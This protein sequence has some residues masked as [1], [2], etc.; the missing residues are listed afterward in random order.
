MARVPAL[1]TVAVAAVAGVAGKAL[2]ELSTEEAALKALAAPAFSLAGVE[3]SDVERLVHK[4]WHEAVRALIALGHR[5]SEGDTQHVATQVRQAVQAE[6][7]RLDDLTRALDRNYGKAV[8][9]SPASQWAQ[10]STHIFLAVKFAQRWNA[11]GALEVENETVEISECCLNFTA[12]GEH[13]FIRRRYRLS[14]ELFRPLLPKAS[15]W[16]LASVGRMSV[17]LSKAKAANWPRLL[18]SGAGTA[19]K[20]L[21]IWR[22]MKEK[23]QNEVDRL[24][25]LVDTAGAGP[26]S[27]GSANAAARAPVSSSSGTSAAAGREPRKAKKGKGAPSKA[28]EEEEDDEALDREVELLSECSKASYAGSTVAEL[29]QS[30]WAET[31]E[32]PRV[33]GRRWLVELYSSQ[34]DGDAEAMKSLMPVWKRLADVFPSMVPGGRVGAVDCRTERELCKKLGL[35]PGAKAK[36]PQ[37]RRFVGS[38]AGGSGNP[39]GDTWTGSTGAS[40]EA[41]AAFGGGREEL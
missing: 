18:S 16:S 29:C 20:N 38:S 37:I 17:T 15:S 33:R 9:V 4:G 26:G 39:L 35:A 14:F 12:F 32:L 6:R 1:L 3:A 34:G 40:I 7:N 41:L 24:P 23:W 25:P 28:V 10:N 19:P 22:D 30:A 11:P 13:S 2:S 36:L 21:G 8:D 31:V 5:G 27:A